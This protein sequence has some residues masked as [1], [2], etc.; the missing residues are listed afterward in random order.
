[1]SGSGHLGDTKIV[2]DADAI[3]IVAVVN[4]FVVELFVVD[5]VRNYFVVVDLALG[6]VGVSFADQTDFPGV[7]FVFI[8]FVC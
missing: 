6:F 2:V 8:G 5:S 1:M 3:D 7:Y 4:G